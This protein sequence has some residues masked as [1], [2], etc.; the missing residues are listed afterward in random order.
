[1]AATPNIHITLDQVLALVEQLSPSDQLRL[2]AR[3]AP[4]VER[5]LTQP[6]PPRTPLYGRFAQH[7]IAPSADD[8]DSTRQEM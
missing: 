4:R 2:I 5:S 6:A 3:I 7:G 1:M 8:I